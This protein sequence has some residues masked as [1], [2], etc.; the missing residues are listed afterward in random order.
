MELVLWTSTGLLFH[1]DY[2]LKMNVEVYSGVSWGVVGLDLQGE[3]LSC[4]DQ[5]QTLGVRLSA[6]I[7][8][9]GRKA[10]LP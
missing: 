3:S 1:Y 4:L 2:Y 10:N 8:S 7:L 9:E 6:A 5:R